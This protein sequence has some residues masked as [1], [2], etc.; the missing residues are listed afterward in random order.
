MATLAPADS[1]VVQGAGQ[2]GRE[3]KKISNGNVNLVIHAGGVMGDEPECVGKLRHNSIQAAG[4]SGAGLGEIEQGVGVPA[5]PDDV[6]FLRGAGLRA[7]PHGAQARKRLLQK[8]YVVLNWGDVGWVQFFSDKP[9]RRLDDLRKL[10]MFT[11]AG[12]NDR[13]ELWQANGFRPVPLPATDII[14]QL[15]MH[16]LDAVP[17]TPLYAW[18]PPVLQPRHT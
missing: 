10:R 4:L 12:S 17:A 11:W 1:H 13:E 9:M 3:W 5:D 14:M 2:H 16:N 6:R 7:R 18:K 15:K 8:G